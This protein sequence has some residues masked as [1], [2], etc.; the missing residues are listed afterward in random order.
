MLIYYL[1]IYLLN[2]NTFF[3][4]VHFAA[5]QQHITITN[6]TVFNG[7]STP[8]KDKYASEEK[9]L[10][11]DMAEFLQHKYHVTDTMTKKTRDEVDDDNKNRQRVIEDANRL[12]T[13]E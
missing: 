4:F 13:G 7:T 6:G 1:L 10:G 9:D 5:K 12:V 3:N 2:V 11:D 8:V